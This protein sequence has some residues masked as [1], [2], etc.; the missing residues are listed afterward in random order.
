MKLYSN[1][2]YLIIFLVLFVISCNDEDHRLK[3]APSGKIENPKVY[4]LKF[5]HD[6]PGESPQHIAA[7][8]FKEIVERKSEGRLQIE[9]FPNQILGSDQEM[10]L[11]AIEGNL[12]IIL[13][14]MAKLSVIVPASLY[15]DLPFFFE[16]RKELY[17]ML[18]GKPGKILREQFLSKGLVGVSFWESGFKHFMANKEIH[19]PEDFKNLNVRVMKN[20]LLADQYKF[21]G[22]KSFF[23]DFLKINDALKDGVINAQENS[24]VSIKNLKLYESQSHLTLSEHGYIGYLLSFSKKTYSKLPEELQEILFS[25]GQEVTAFEREE[26]LKK[27]NDYLKKLQEA[28]IK[29]TK[30]TNEEKRSFKAAL[31]PLLEKYR[32]TIGYKLFEI[33]DQ[34]RS[35]KILLSEDEILIGLDA[36]LFAGSSPSG[37]SIKRGAKIAIN[38]INNKGGILGRRLR[39]ISK[40]HSGISAR[41]IMNIEYFSKLKNLVA[42]IGG[43]HSPVALSEL[44]TI[45]KKN[46][47][48]LDPW[49]AATNIVENGHNPNYVFRLSVRDE[50]AGPFLVNEALK[51]HKKIA[52]LLENTGWGRSNH[53][54]MGAVFKEKKIQ[55][56]TVQWF[57]W[58]EPNLYKQLFAVKNSDADAIILVSNAP[59]GKTLI[60]N[61]V[62]NNIVL[63]VFSHWGITGGNF[64][65]EVKDELKLIDLKALQ[66]FSFLKPKNEKTKLFIKKYFDNL[67]LEKKGN[68]DAPVGTA[69]AYD[70]VHLLALA[71]QSANSLDRVEIRNALENIP[72]YNGLV[73]NYRRPFSK[74]NHEA[75]DSSDFF[76]AK[77]DDEGRIIP[78]IN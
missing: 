15:L 54:S 76:L 77:Y 34:I 5:G 42:V 13:P 46:M 49:A 32:S 9:I 52:L 1:L 44:E 22:G 28:K 78:V 20:R 19:S 23:I 29:I 51:K 68:I 39:L 67:E 7:K 24:L 61:M 4:K 55:P 21:L 48:Y 56:A 66:T 45:H 59:E 58:K 57:N 33:T 53:K 65:K 14:P 41:G 71:M 2:K 17:E 12:D 75:L 40:D 64:G 18:D 35:E 43:I 16:D 72:S 27:E 74:N 38:E 63:P 70:I 11:K 10:I 3:K 69:H 60:N 50:Y 25:T 73:K 37:Y 30:L 36:D 26:T 47:I 8:K 31:S 62:E 6:M